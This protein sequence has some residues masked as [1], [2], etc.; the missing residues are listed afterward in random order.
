VSDGMLACQD[1]FFWP[2]CHAKVSSIIHIKNNLDIMIFA[3]KGQ[4]T[5]FNS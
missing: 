3:S 4:V 5:V 1:L 2:W